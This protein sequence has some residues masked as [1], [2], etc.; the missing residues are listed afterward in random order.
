MMPWS[1]SLFL[2]PVKNLDPKGS[3]HMFEGFL[4]VKYWINFRFSSS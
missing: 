2:V 4:F 1:F 3:T